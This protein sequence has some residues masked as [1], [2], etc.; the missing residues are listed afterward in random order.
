MYES[1]K[2]GRK[3]GRF[4]RGEDEESRLFFAFRRRKI[5]EQAGKGD[6][7]NIIGRQG[8]QRRDANRANGISSEYLNEVGVGGRE[9]G[10][11]G[12]TVVALTLALQARGNSGAKEYTR[13][14]SPRSRVRT[15]NLDRQDLCQRGS[16]PDPIIPSRISRTLNKTRRKKGG[17]EKLELIEDAR[18]FNKRTD[19]RALPF[20]DRFTSFVPRP[21]FFDQLGGTRVARYA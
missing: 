7:I 8:E 1:A 10:S 12:E 11:R 18:V 4:D 14:Y 13:R 3:E 6:Y 17:G 9:E 20:Y 2:E 19:H 16:R 5:A 21:P 15:A